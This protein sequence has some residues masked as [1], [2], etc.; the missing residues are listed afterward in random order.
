MKTDRIDKQRYDVIII[1]SGIGGLTAGALLARAGKSVLLL[2]QHDRP[3]GYAHGFKRKR[4]QFDS[5]VHL[6]S[7]CGLHGYRGGQVIRKVLQA[8][9]CYQDMEFIAVDP[10]C[11]A[12]YPG[13]TISLPQSID[14]YVAALAEHFP[15]QEQGLRGLIALCVEISEQAAKADDMLGGSDSGQVREQLSTL[16]Q[17]RRATLADVWGE[18]IQDERLRSIFATNWPY[19]GLP[20]EKVSF[21]YWAT[22]FAG[23][24]V[25]GAYYCKGGFQQFANTLAQAI[26]RNGG[27]TA[28]KCPVRQIVIEAGSVA[29]V[30]L[31]DGR[32][33]TAGSVVANADM[34]QTVYRLVGEQHFPRRF[35]SKLSRM[36]HSASIFAVYIATDLDLQALN[37][38]HESFYY[39]DSDHEKNFTAVQEGEFTWLSV[40]AP[41]LVDPGLAPPGRHIIMLTTL[42]SYD[43]VDSW[44]ESKPVFVQKMLD[45]AARYIP[46]LK[47]HLLLVDAGS[48]ATMQRYTLNSHGAAYGWDASPEQVGANRIGNRA[49]IAGLYFA[50]H[51]SSPGGGV[52]GASV[53]GMQA[54]QEILGIREQRC[55]WHVVNQGC[56]AGAVDLDDR[57]AGC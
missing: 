56:A 13:L 51:W 9:D 50:G 40:T 53:S 1:G 43:C 11:H 36:S 48:P 8:V 10:F 29:G 34:R 19:V 27:V 47:D 38:A 20:P 35:I 2:E 30:R 44:Q 16:F 14:A 12:V 57:L 5:G 46:G 45:L 37:V 31:E 22:M 24:L 6:T 52:Y 41:T 15:D 49:P 17:Y 54:A 25:D 21:L 26:T 4:Y 32:R 18:F 33:I 3:G 23:Y 39:Q 42:L 55:F 28:Y 7:G